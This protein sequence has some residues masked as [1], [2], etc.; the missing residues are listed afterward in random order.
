[1]RPPV[2]V[3]PS[4]LCVLGSALLVLGAAGWEALAIEEDG[5]LV[6]WLVLGA[7]AIV[8][9]LA[10]MIMPMSARWSTALCVMVTGGLGVVAMGLGWMMGTDD[11]IGISLAVPAGLASLGACLLCLLALAFV[12][13]Y[14]SA[15]EALY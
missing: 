11:A 10:A 13:Q 12:H 4:A 6:P 8:K 15:L 5:S 9:L 3:W 7:G 1:M 2:I 14:R